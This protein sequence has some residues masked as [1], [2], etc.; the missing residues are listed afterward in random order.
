M[1]VSYSLIYVDKNNDNSLLILKNDD[2]NCII[3]V[4]SN[5]VLLLRYQKGDIHI[6]MASIEE[7]VEEQ[8]KGMLDILG[9]R[10]YGKTE[11]INSAISNALKNADSKSGGSG[12]NF[13]DIQLMLENSNA[14][15]CK[16]FIS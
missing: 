13:P 12:N 7:K 2:K 8:Y 3:Y 15:F 1:D 10:H 6:H 16:D 9:V 11:K 4:V 5:D 14:N